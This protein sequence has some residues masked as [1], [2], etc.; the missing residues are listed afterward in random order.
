M[1]IAENEGDLDT[2][3][4]A[5]DEA[6]AAF[7]AVGDRWG[8]ATTQSE[9]SSLLVLDGDL[10]GAERALAQTQELLAELGTSAIGGMVQLR[11]ADIRARR[12]DLDGA[13]EMLLESL[14]ERESYSEETAMIKVAA[15][16]AIML[17]GDIERAR[18]L[19]DDALR[20]SRSVT[21][22]FDQGHVLAM[23]LS[24]AGMLEVEAEALQRAHELFVEARPVALG[25]N[26]MPLIAML[27]T[28]LAALAS[29][30]GH[31]LDSAEMLGAG[32]RLRGSED[33]TDLEI[34]RL[35]AA[36]RA[37]LGTEAFEEAYLRGRELSRDEAIARLDPA[38]IRVT[39][40]S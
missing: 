10:D 30:A 29:R 11:L 32:A 19:V 17:Q 27:G 34:A 14:E 20:V 37:E 25:T 33:P 28:G 24:A 12:G 13:T 1:Q 26:D 5:L 16:R 22:R 35:T 40:H 15:A 2:M 7:T 8:L 23:A 36:L 3:R 6:V 4:A 18:Q 38:L 39:D 31:P 21:Q 9:R